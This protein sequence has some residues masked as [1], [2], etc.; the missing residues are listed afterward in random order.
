MTLEIRRRRS[1]VGSTLSVNR[2]AHGL[3]L[4]LESTRHGSA[5]FSHHEMSDGAEPSGEPGAIVDGVELSVGTNEDLLGRVLGLGPRPM[6]S[7]GAVTATDREDQGGMP[8]VDPAEGLEIPRSDQVQ[9][10]A[11]V[12]RH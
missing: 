4:M 6:R 8:I 12:R 1:R 7:S 10:V 2:T 3:A 11:V 5:A 9:I